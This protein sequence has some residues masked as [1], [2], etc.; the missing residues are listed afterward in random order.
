MDQYMDWYISRDFIGNYFDNHKHSLVPAKES[1]KDRKIM[2]SRSVWCQTDVICIEVY[3]SWWRLK[4]NTS[5]SPGEETP[6]E[7]KPTL[8]KGEH[9]NVSSSEVRWC[10]CVGCSCSPSSPIDSNVSRVRTQMF[11]LVKNVFNYENPKEMRTK[12]YLMNEIL[13]SEE[14]LQWS[15]DNKRWVS[16][17]SCFW[18]NT[19]AGL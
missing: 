4:P 10:R 3:G 8:Q 15:I 17:C 18:L 12:E 19:S 16:L 1:T 11:W 6:P 7:N 5:T 14:E 2:T 13:K 9:L